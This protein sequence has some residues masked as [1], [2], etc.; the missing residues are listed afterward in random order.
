VSERSDDSERPDAGYTPDRVPA[1]RIGAWVFGLGLVLALTLVGLK[2]LF[3]AMTEREVY[4]KQLQPVAADL[5]RQRDRDESALGRY[6][7]VDEKRGR[8]R[9]PITRAM[10]LLVAEPARLQPAAPASAPASTPASAAA[11]ATRPEVRR[12]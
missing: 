11:P 5:V 2:Q 7:V 12:Q 4:D 1:L 9:I 8:Y 10:E 3:V 6:E